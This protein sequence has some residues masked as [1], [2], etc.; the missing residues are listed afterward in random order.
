[1]SEERDRIQGGSVRQR[2]D[3]MTSR[4]DRMMGAETEPY[5]TYSE[6]GEYG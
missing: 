5:L 6:D 1:M 3:R 2:E 4:K